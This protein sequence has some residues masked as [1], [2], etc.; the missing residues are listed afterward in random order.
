[1]LK[2]RGQKGLD[3]QYAN[4]V[5]ANAFIGSTPLDPAW[6]Y[7]SGIAAKNPATATDQDR[8]TSG[9][10]LASSV[11]NYAARYVELPR[12]N[13][14][15]RFNAGVR[16]KLL[17]TDPHS[18]STFWWSD[19]ADGLDSR[20]TRAV[21]LAKATQ[22]VL[23]FWT[24][25]E[26]EKDYDYAYVAVSTDNGQHWATLPAPA[27]TK[28]DPNGANLGSGF[29][30]NSGGERSAWIQQQVDLSAFAGKQVL[31]RFEYVTDGALSLHGFAVDDIQI[32][33]VL[34]DDAEA[35]NGWQADGFVRSTNLVAQRY[36][37]QLLRFTASGATVDRR[38]VDNG[39]VVFDVDT[40]S[41]RKAP[42][43]AVTGVAVRTTQP[44][45]F[46]V[47]VEKR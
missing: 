34:V 45:P 3:E 7:P 2:A 16:T 15:V 23:S 19:R 14:S 30:A 8:V 24:W 35:D 11:H 44:V 12:G 28:D 9:N 42:L 25:Y 33:G 41:D 21:D 38:T 26:I 18:G 40:S 6:S 43:L 32:P 29:T 46:E 10:K 5:A 31:L 47:A 20:L 17:P 1:M 4:F 22:P 27:T 39:S 13:I 37:V 36:L